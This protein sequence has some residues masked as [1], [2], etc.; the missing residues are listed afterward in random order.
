MSTQSNITTTSD[1]ISMIDVDMN[2]NNSRIRRQFELMEPSKP[3]N[4]AK[5]GVK[6]KKAAPRSKRKASAAQ[7][8]EAVGG[9]SFVEPEDDNFEVKVEQNSQ[10][11][12]SGKKRKS[13]EMSIDNDAAQ[14]E[15]QPSQPPPQLPLTKRRATRS[16]VTHTNGVGDPIS[17]IDQGDE[18]YMTNTENTAPQPLPI[19]KKA[20]RGGKK[21]ASSST[22]KASTTSTASKA[23][24]RATIPND[25]DI[26]A[27]LEA[28]L[29]KPLTEDE[30]EP[31]PPTMPKTRTR[32]LTRTRP[33]SRNVTASTAPVRRA[34][35]AS[36]LPVER[37]S[38]A[39]VGAL[40]DDAKNANFEG[41][42]AVEI[43]LTAID[44]AKQ[45]IISE[46]DRH[47]VSKAKSHNRPPSKPAKA[48]KKCTET[49][50][51]GHS[52]N[53]SQAIQQG[54]LATK[55]TS[56]EP[57]NRQ[58]SDQPQE[59]KIRTSE[60]SAGSVIGDNISE[61][62]SSVLAPTVVHEESAN[63]AHGGRANQ[64]R[65][66]KVGRPRS[67]AA[68]KGR[69][70]K[71]G[72]ATS[73]M[74]EE[75]DHVEK[76]DATR[77]SL[78]ALVDIKVPDRQ[79]S[80]EE[81]TLPEAPKGDNQ[82]TDEGDKQIAMSKEGSELPPSRALATEPAEPVEARWVT[83]HE[84][85]ATIG[86]ATPADSQDQGEGRKTP[87]R[88]PSPRVQV[89]SAHE[90]PK[91][92]ASPQSSDAE[93]QPPS[94]R[95]SALRPPLLPQTPSKTQAARVPLA[96]TT[97][98]VSPLKR[99]ISR[100]QTTLPWE[101]IEFEKIFK[102]PSADKENIPEYTVDGFKQGLS[103]PE[104]KLTV[105]EWIRWNAKRGEEKLRADCERLMGRFEGEGVRALKTLEGIVCTE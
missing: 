68:K 98:T 61:L 31:D 105:E 42:N 54:Y 22:R 91:M 46:T 76:V 86:I 8:V 44:H 84:N 81:L 9:S 103:S 88:S 99:N 29:D 69:A 53:E 75:V 5:K 71:K 58:T 30:A 50:H 11:R 21:R 89:S 20:T 97:P 15:L 6:G 80:G 63:E 12:A 25:E 60:I 10:Q 27:A 34:T 96:A 78:V 64:T 93:N 77:S 39:S 100:L 49:V 67:T 16:S 51:D 4:G 57:A 70:V 65:A 17:A 72:A 38:M 59:R 62:N 7:Q 92:V 82:A 40:A 66:K 2:E 37:D 56:R 26:D 32:R 18:S 35:R 104:K 83:A 43:A 3:T 24:L 48:I 74:I 85:K 102:S 19:S 41:P 90:T 45:E 36:A 33:G 14:L 1:D 94:S 79:G 28:D 101:S 55:D 87:V 13:D 95:P 52:P 47:V 73:R 23:S